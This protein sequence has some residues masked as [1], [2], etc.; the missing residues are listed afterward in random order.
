LVQDLVTLGINAAGQGGYQS[1]SSRGHYRVG[2]NVGEAGLSLERDERVYEHASER[3]EGRVEALQADLGC[4]RDR[5]RSRKGCV[6]PDQG[7]ACLIGRKYE[8]QRWQE[9]SQAHGYS[10]FQ[11]RSPRSVHPG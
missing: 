3:S 9:R 6:V 1:Q 5:K 4:A 10:R 8:Q 2:A 7:S 11:E